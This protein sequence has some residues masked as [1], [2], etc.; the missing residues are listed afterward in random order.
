MDFK[1]IA[2]KAKRMIAQRGGPESVKE[3]ALEVE[4]ILKGEGSA[5]DKAKQAAAA[6][7]EPGAHTEP[8]AS[9]QPTE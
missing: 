6:I 3:D 8:G 4:G 5:T 2:D 9:G 1:T 7:K